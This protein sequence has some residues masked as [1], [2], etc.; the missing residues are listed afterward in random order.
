MSGPAAKK[1]ALDIEPC[2][3]RG[4]RLRAHHLDQK[5]PLSRLAEAAGACGLQNSPPGAWETAAFNRIS[6]CTLQALENALYSEKSLLQAWSFRGAPMVFPTVESAV[7]LSALAAQ[8]GEQPW[9]YTRGLSAAL[10]YLDMSFDPLLS[11]VREAAAYLNTH[12]VCSKEALDQTLAELVLPH[13]PPEKRDLW[14]APSMYGRPDRQTVGGAAVSFLLRPCSFLSLVVFGRRQGMTPSFTS[15]TNWTGH[16][17]DQADDPGRA[18]TRKFLHCYGPATPAAFARWLGASP[19]QAR[20]LWSRAEQDMCPVR[21]CGR[22]AYLLTDDLP[23]LLSAAADER[24][25]LLGPHDPYL[26]AADRSVL[27]EDTRLHRY[28]W[29]TVA[30][31][32]AVLLDGRIAGIWTAV[33]QNGLSVS[34]RLF[35]PLSA[36]QRRTLTER[37][38]AYA[39]FRLQKLNAVTIAA[40][41]DGPLCD[42]QT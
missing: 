6:T 36:P 4:H 12:T 24:L 10:D 40:M 14:N 2:R 32:G 39:A 34:V 28:V 30:N 3:I 18:L 21:V 41:D 19:A 15:F 25:L 13:L 26:D 23:G 33:K 35:E 17:P 31:P 9:I 20:R 16:G 22:T 38:E 7:F 1:R 29:K 37:A 11:L 5:L 8:P 42:S 27:L